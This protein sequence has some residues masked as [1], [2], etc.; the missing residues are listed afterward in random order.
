MT[1]YTVEQMYNW[2]AQDYFSYYNYIQQE[3][4]RQISPY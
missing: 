4:Q 3:Y 1:P 2:Q